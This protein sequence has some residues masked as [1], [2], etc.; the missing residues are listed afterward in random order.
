MITSEG[1]SDKR[2]A[3]NE[4]RAEN[5]PYSHAID[6]SPWRNRRQFDDA[7]TPL[8][9]EGIGS[10]QEGELFHWDWMNIYGDKV[11]LSFENLPTDE[12]IGPHAII[13]MSQGDI[14]AGMEVNT[15]GVRIHKDLKPREGNRI[16]DFG[17]VDQL[18]IL[19]GMCARAL[20]TGIPPDGIMDSAMEARAKHNERYGGWDDRR[21]LFQYKLK[22]FSRQLSEKHFL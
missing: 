9:V 3:P 22:D 6:A 1:S 12:L 4:N 15:V 10:Q 16:E 11:S 14:E 13:H 21:Q 17:E 20:E 7:I 19:I 5:P 2:G 18:P 8:V